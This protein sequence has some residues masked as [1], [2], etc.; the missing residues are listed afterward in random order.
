MG[1]LSWHWLA[2][3]CR[4]LSLH[5]FRLEDTRISAIQHQ[6]HVSSSD[7][8]GPKAVNTN[9]PNSS[10]LSICVYGKATHSESISLLADGRLFTMRRLFTLVTVR[11]TLAF[12]F[13]IIAL[14]FLWLRVS[15][16]TDYLNPADSAADEAL[17]AAIRMLE[18]TGQIAKK[19]GASDLLSRPPAAQS[20]SIPR[21]IHQS[22]KSSE[23]PFR[24]KSWN[25]SCRRKHKDWEWVLWTDEDNLD[26][27][28]RY[29]PW[30]E[31]AYSALPSP[32]FRADFMRSLYMYKFGG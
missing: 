4:V 12:I 19:T 22:W 29:F 13:T 10:T 26:L 1:A 17:D 6:R 7:E 2:F 23:L 8:T 24:F 3:I 32:I 20:N 18:E 27:V 30:L 11:S 5:V 31:E 14:W 21:I 25:L 28:R 15:E 9:L 16:S